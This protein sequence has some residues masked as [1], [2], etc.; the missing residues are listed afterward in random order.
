MTPGRDNSLQENQKKINSRKSI[1]IRKA[2]KLIC[3]IKKAGS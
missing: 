2:F 1:A 3:F